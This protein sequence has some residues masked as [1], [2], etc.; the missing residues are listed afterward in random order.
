MV[1]PFS[2]V[3]I[4]TLTGEYSVK[5]VDICQ[6]VGDSLNPAIDIGQIEGAFIQ[7]MGW[8]TT[9]ELVWG[10]DGRL[11]TNNPASYKIP[12]IG[13]TPPIFNV[14]LLPDSPNV[15]ATIY[16]SKAVGEPPLMLAIS[17]W[18]AIRDAVASIS[19]YQQLPKLDAPATPERVLAACQ[20][21]TADQQAQDNA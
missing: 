8:L 12:T 2:E 10:D 16:H 4:D 17:V 20:S 21:I 7:G 9:E 11:Q 6:D 5:Q 3:V 1:Q 13:D 15:E 18:C 14:E 19:N